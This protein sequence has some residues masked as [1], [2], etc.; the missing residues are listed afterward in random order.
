MQT[1]LP[2]AL[3]RGDFRRPGISVII[4]GI[5]VIFP[6][7]SVIVFWVVLGLRGFKRHENALKSPQEP[8]MAPDSAENDGNGAPKPIYL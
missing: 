6:G 5:S 1:L 3:R 2:G 8:L 4:P 7:I